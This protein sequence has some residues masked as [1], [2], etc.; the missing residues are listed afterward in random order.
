MSNLNYI[1]SRIKNYAFWVSLFAFV[2]LIINLKYPVYKAQY[3]IIV[4]G[5][6]ALLVAG[7]IANNPTTI[8]SGFGDDKINF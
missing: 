6:L 4:N 7:G 3:E 5:F 8:N 1:K 2:G